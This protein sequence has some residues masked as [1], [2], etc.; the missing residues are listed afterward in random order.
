MGQVKRLFDGRPR[1]AA[2]QQRVAIGMILALNEQFVEG[3][4]AP[5]PVLLAQHHFPVAGQ[6]PGGAGDDCGWSAVTAALPDHHP[7]AR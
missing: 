1:P 5:V 3:G 2:E 7:V 4:M 6:R